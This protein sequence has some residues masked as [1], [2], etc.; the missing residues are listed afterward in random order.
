MLA[1]EKKTF[2]EDEVSE[3]LCI[4]VERQGYLYVKRAEMAGFIYEGTDCFPR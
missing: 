1:V 4:E 3:M 2:Y